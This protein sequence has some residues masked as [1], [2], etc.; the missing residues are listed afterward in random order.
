MK[1]NAIWTIGHSTH[2]IHDFLDLLKAHEINYLADIRRFPGSRRY[3]QFNSDALKTTLS[4]NN[5]GY[6]HFEGLGGRRNPKPDSKNDAWRVAAFR[7]YAD[8]M[9]SQ[10]FKREIELLEKLGREKRVV[11]MCSE[12]VWWSCH[13]ALVSDYLK[14][15]GWTVFHIMTKAKAE[16]HPWTKPARIVDGQL[17]YASQESLFGHQEQSF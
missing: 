17:S 12:A 10:E 7:G 1:G 5:I 9:A 11:Y 16:E 15:N 2:S 14:S 4:E 13:R 6:G 3:P 8:Y